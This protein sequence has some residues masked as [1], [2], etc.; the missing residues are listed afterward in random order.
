[1]RLI[2]KKWTITDISD[3]ALPEGLTLAEKV[4]YWRKLN[5]ASF[6]SEML[7]TECGAHY[8]PFLL[9]DMSVACERIKR[10]YKGQIGR[11]HV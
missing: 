7:G 9:P 11:A 4:L 6:L 1:M 8:D 3:L 5:N 10:A 2:Q